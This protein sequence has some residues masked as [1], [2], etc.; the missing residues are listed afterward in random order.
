[1]DKA[2][3]NVLSALEASLDRRVRSA[4]TT[5]KSLAVRMSLAEINKS[6]AL[7][8]AWS[9]I[10]A[11]M[12]EAMG[13]EISPATLRKIYCTINKGAKTKPPANSAQSPAQAPVRATAPAPAPAESVAPPAAPKPAPPNAADAA[14]ASEDRFKTGVDLNQY[15][16][17][18][19]PPRDWGLSDETI[20][21]LQKTPLYFRPHTHIE[22]PK[23]TP[24]GKGGGE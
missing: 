21:F 16:D 2:E 7:G 19:W 8:L 14:D 15:R 24:G 11:S 17:E 9:E 23:A 1:M 6:R 22:R 12:R 13:C 5:K 3:N 4:V 20:A 10:A 18:V